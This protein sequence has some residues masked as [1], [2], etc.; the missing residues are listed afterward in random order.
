MNPKLPP[1]AIVLHTPWMNGDDGKYVGPIG[2]PLLT[3]CTELA[4][5]TRSTPILCNMYLSWDRQEFFQEVDDTAGQSPAVVDE[6][7]DR[8]LHKHSFVHGH[9]TIRHTNTVG[10]FDQLDD[11]DGFG[12]RTVS[13]TSFNHR[14]DVTISD[15]GL[16]VSE[17]GRR[18]LF[19][20]EHHEVSAYWAAET[21]DAVEVPA[22]MLA[23]RLDNND[24][25]SRDWLRVD[26]QSMRRD[27]RDPDYGYAPSF[28]WG[29][30]IKIVGC[31]PKKGLQ[32]TK[33][34][35]HDLSPH[36]HD[37]SISD[38]VGKSLADKSDDEPREYIGTH[39]HQA[40]ISEA[41]GV[42]HEATNL[43]RNVKVAI[44]I[45]RRDNAEILP[46]TYVPYIAR[47]AEMRDVLADFEYGGMT[48]DV[49][50]G[51]GDKRDPLLLTSPHPNHQPEPGDEVGSNTHH[52]EFDHEH[53]VSVGAASGPSGREGDDRKVAIANSG[54]THPPTHIV[55]NR[56]RSDESANPLKYRR[57]VFVRFGPDTR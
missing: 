25:M 29:T 11:P 51:N 15:T 39:T 49:V 13:A 21:S 33:T 30:A 44:W 34:H 19:D 12:E 10:G 41:L 43:R 18:R 8:H 35:G 54:H 17:E 56:L 24:N 6:T 7:V 16:T 47:N 28:W 4:E 31:T 55:E 36:T 52:H 27:P 20:P 37:I 22:G 57:I 23:F 53:V 32:G 40:A 48:W 5:L 2:N 45:A 38:S 26:W 9:P 14:H 46:G 42:L 1:G 50:T 3:Q